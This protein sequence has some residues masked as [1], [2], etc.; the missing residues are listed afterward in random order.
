MS[1]LTKV[2]ATLATC[3]LPF[4]AAAQNAP[5]ITPPPSSVPV[6][7]LGT[8][9][10]G[11]QPIISEML[12]IAGPQSIW[13]KFRLRDGITPKTWFNIDTSRSTINTEIGLYDERY[14][15]I[16]DDDFSGGGVAL[17]NSLAS[18]LT[19]GGGS[20][21]RLGED[22]P[23]WVGARIDTGWNEKGGVWRPYLNAGLYYL[24]VVGYDADFSQN[25]NPNL[26]VST[27]FTGSGT[28]RVKLSSGRVPS[29]RW[30]EVWQGYDAG[31]APG[32]AQPLV[33]S[34]SL[35]TILSVLGTAERDVF[36]I[37]ICDPSVFRATCTLTAEWGNVYGARLFLLDR[38]RRGISGI[39]NTITGTD[40]TLTAPAGTTLAPGDYYLAVSGNCGGPAGWQAVPYDDYGTGGRAL[41]DFSN[42]S[43][44]NRSIAPNGTGR[45]SPMATSGRQNFC[46]DNTAFFSRIT[47]SGACYIDYTCPADLDDGSGSGT[48]DGGITL[49]DLLYFIQR[50]ESG[51]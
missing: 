3:V 22:G 37:R 47:L 41:W 48:P 30:H 12:P 36:K 15:R 39:N 28:I 45:E 25:P 31:F 21:A 16:D 20:G 6:I 46:V 34:G 8:F 9:G 2:I 24:V 7:D 1:S 32:I 42:Q 26:N 35:T 4:A 51:C 13:F 29:T 27:N 44:W 14:Y 11:D 33:G 18:A 50:F 23:G 40:T 19:Y 49:D 17:N 5:P 10:V 38:N 43:T